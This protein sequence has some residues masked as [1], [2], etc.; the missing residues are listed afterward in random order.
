MYMPTMCGRRGP[1]LQP[2]SMSLL[3]GADDGPG[4]VRRG[5]R[6]HAPRTEPRPRGIRRR[7]RTGDGRGGA[8]LLAVSAPHLSLAA[9]VVGYMLSISASR[10]ALANH[11]QI[12]S[13]AQKP[14]MTSRLTKRTSQLDSM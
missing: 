13:T 4:A 12:T 8:A 9:T 7:C 11:D 3:D 10:R 6:R 2:G 5:D 1:G 14:R